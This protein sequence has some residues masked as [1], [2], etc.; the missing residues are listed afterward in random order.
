MAENAVLMPMAVQAF[1]VTE[2]FPQSKYRIAPLIQ[3]D[4]SSLRAERLL[5]Q[6][7][8]EQL[9]L[10]SHRLL[11]KHKTRFVN[12]AT[13][14]ARKERVGI[15]LSWTIPKTYRQG[16]TATA[17]VAVDHSVA[18]LKAGYIYDTKTSTP[19]SSGGSTNAPQDVAAADIKFRNIPTRLRHFS[20]SRKHFATTRQIQMPHIEFPLT[21]VES[22]NDLFADFQPHNNSV[23][24]LHDD[25][26]FGTRNEIKDATLDYLVVDFHNRPEN[27][28]FCVAGS[29]KEADRPSYGEIL[30]ACAMDLDG[31]DLDW[32]S[33]TQLR[34]NWP[35]LKTDSASIRL[36]C[37]GTLTNVP[38]QRSGLN[39]EAK[40][41]SVQLQD[42][43]RKHHPVAIGTN[44]LDAL[45]AL[46]HV[47]YSDDPKCRSQT[48]QMLFKMVQLIVVSD[49]FDA[50]EKAEDQISTNDWVPAPSGTVWSVSKPEKDSS[51]AGDGKKT[52]LVLTATDVQAL[53]NLNDCEAAVSAMV[54]EMHHLYQ[55][56]FYRWWNAMEVRGT[57]LDAAQKGHKYAITVLLGEVKELN[58]AIKAAN[59]EEENALTKLFSMLD[60]DAISAPSFGVHQDPIILFAGVPSGCPTGFADKVKVRFAYQLPQT[61][62]VK[63]LTQEISIPEWYDLT[64]KSFP[65]VAP[66]IQQIAW[67]SLVPHRDGV[68][69]SPYLSQ[70]SF[71]EGQGWLP[72]FIEWEIEYHHVDWEIWRFDH[73]PDGSWRYHIAVSK[74]LAD[75]MDPNASRW[76]KFSGRTP[77]MP[78]ASSVLKYRIRQLFSRA[79]Q[80]ADKKTEANSLVDQI[81]EIEYFSA[82]LAGL[83]D[84]LMTVIRGAHV[85][86]HADDDLAR[87]ACLNQIFD[88]LSL[89]QRKHRTADFHRS[90]VITHTVAQA[91][92]YP[93]THG[94][95]LFT[96]LHIVDKFGQIVSCVKPA[97]F[98]APRTAIYPCVSPHLPCEPIP[99]GWKANDDFIKTHLHASEVFDIRAVTSVASTLHRGPE[100]ASNI[101]SGFM[102]VL[103]DIAKNIIPR[104]L[105][106]TIGEGP[107]LEAFQIDVELQLHLGQETE[108]VPIHGEIKWSPGRLELLGEIWD[109]KDQ[110]LVPFNIHPFR[111]TFSE[112]RPLQLPGETVV[113][114]IFLRHLFDKGAKPED[115]PQGI[116][117][118]LSKASVSVTLGDWEKVVIT[119]KLQCSAPN[120][121]PDVMPPIWLDELQVLYMRDISAGTNTFELRSNINLKAPGYIM[122]RETNALVRVYIGY[123]NGW[124][125]AAEAVGLKLANLYSLFPVDGSNHAMIHLMS[126]VWIPRFSVGVRFAAKR[127]GAIS[128]DGTLVIGPLEMDLKYNHDGADWQLS[129]DF[130]SATPGK[131]EATMEEL[132]GVFVREHVD[133]LPEYIRNFRLPLSKISAKLTF[134]S[135]RMPEAAGSESKSVVVFSFTVSVPLS[136]SASADKERF[137]FVFAR[138]QEKKGA[139]PS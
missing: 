2:D 78:Q 79:Q 63:P 107:S 42:L 115:F 11:A 80:A 14:E 76:R 105:S 28:L 35:N 50:Q 37:H 69:R 119:G 53:A 59:G 96:K 13:G 20:G 3:P 52:N 70:E 82:P 24:S 125:L 32:G 136:S 12:V 135:K 131:Q 31:S 113:D 47:Q 83:Q 17:K 94:Q 19:S 23:I 123:E 124:T 21:I 26:D 117:L 30:D 120:K 39:L 44:T 132:L 116:P 102:D 72:L 25:L 6:D 128:I 54:R 91:S 34:A 66:F 45:L 127:A 110:S 8:M 137:S 100:S 75:L 122:S 56:I 84:H 36:M 67:D 121:E 40:S 114:K 27:E 86:P 74:P 49:N 85:R 10:S 92:F 111:E 97:T 38:F 112:V 138:M 60:L 90:M 88:N 16:I 103:S 61:P 43:V 130:K 15:Y 87:L 126:S 98:D 5:A 118:T 55:N 134:S 65:D 64:A 106:L 133:S 93:V 81:A 46:L 7:V 58:Y 57:A 68:P 48:E 89:R 95:F 62:D 139:F 77:I 18:K 104:Q 108:H 129:A 33:R 1:V 9:Q 22:G 51:E 101:E 73:D 41:P 71:G 29:V 99:K 109:L 4:Y